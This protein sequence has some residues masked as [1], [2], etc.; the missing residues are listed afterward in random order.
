MFRSNT[1]SPRQTGRISQTGSLA[2]TGI[3]MNG[4]LIIRDNTESPKTIEVALAGTEG[5]ILG[6]SDSKSN[7][8]VDIDL[9]GFDALEKGISRRHS[10]LV[11]YDDR[12]HVVD[13]S[14]VNG[15][16]L[17]GQRLM[18]ETPYMLNDGDQLTLAQLALTIFHREN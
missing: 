13:L 18:A 1:K 7:Y 15:S 2:G 11:Y 4:I 9:S 17:N 12:L 10:A 3:P 8:V 14:S 16:F 5:F 6:R